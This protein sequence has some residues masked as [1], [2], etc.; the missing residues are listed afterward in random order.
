MVWSG[1]LK[2]ISFG[3]RWQTKV[4]LSFCTGPWLRIGAVLLLTIHCKVPARPFNIL[5]GS[6]FN[7][8]NSVERAWSAIGT[9][10]KEII[11]ILQST[12]WQRH[13]GREPAPI[14]PS[15]MQINR[16]MKFN[17]AIIGDGMRERLALTVIQSHSNRIREVRPIDSENRFFRIIKVTKVTLHV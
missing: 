10:L 9:E 6:F 17:S 2:G 7:R 3:L 5:R 12:R 4:K 8:E 13:F 11:S 1:K 14:N 16:V 15:I